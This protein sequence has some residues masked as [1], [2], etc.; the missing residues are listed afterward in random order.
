MIVLP[1]ENAPIE[2]HFDIINAVQILW[3]LKTEKLGQE[4]SLLQ[5]LKDFYTK[6]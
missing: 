1:I 5:V 2:N 4:V 6:S 3:T